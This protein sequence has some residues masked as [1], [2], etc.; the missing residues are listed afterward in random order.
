MTVCATYT[1]D[2][3]IALHYAQRAIDLYLE[4]NF[5]FGEMGARSIR[6]L[7]RY[8]LGEYHAGLQDARNAH[9]PLE[10][11]GKWRLL[12]YNHIYQGLLL[13]ELGQL[14]SAW[15]HAQRVLSLAQAA[16]HPE[17]RGTGCQ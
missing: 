7:V 14:G 8:Y 10:T 2:L 9:R 6:A 4:A 11:L 15:E 5:P 17:V 13:M 12:A 16:G 3:S 1:A